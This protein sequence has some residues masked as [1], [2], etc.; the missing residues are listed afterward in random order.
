VVLHPVFDERL[1]HISFDYDSVYGPIHS[2]WT[3]GAT[4]EWHATIPAK[5][6]IMAAWNVS[7]P[8]NTTGWL[9]LSAMESMGYSFEVGPIDGLKF[10]PTITT[11][12]G[13][14]GYFLPSGSYMFTITLP[15]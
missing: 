7:I 2:D 15:Q 8:A 6:G 3:V 5:A 12:D 1:G 4:A 9:P 13:Q 14:R 10:V 11:R